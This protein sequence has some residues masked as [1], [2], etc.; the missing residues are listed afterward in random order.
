MPSLLQRLLPR[1]FGDHDRPIAKAPPI[2][3]AHG[4]GRPEDVMPAMTGLQSLGARRPLISS[5]GHIVGFE[6]QVGEQTFQRLVRRGDQ[7]AQAAHVSAVLASARLIGQSGRIGF[8]RFPTGWLL[9]ATTAQVGP[10]TMV[11]LE[12]DENCE[13]TPQLALDTE[14]AVGRLRSAG[15]KV[16]WT[17]SCHINAVPDFLLLHQQAMPMAELLKRMQGLPKAWSAIPVVVTDI[18]NLEDLELALHHGISWGCGAP[19]AL[20]AMPALDKNLPVPPEVRRVGHLLHQL[21]TGAETPDIVAEIKRDVGL[22]YRLLR[23]INSASFAQLNPGTTIEQAA[24]MLGRNELYRWF[25]ML[26]IQFAGQRKTSFALQEITLWHSRLMELLALEKNDPAAGQLF[27]LGLAS[28]L[29]L[30]LK[31]SPTEIAS[32]LNLPETARQALL[33][34][35]GP[36]NV[37]LQTAMELERPSQLGSNPELAHFGG[38][39][40]VLQLSDQAWTW[41]ADNSQR[42]GHGGAA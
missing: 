2:A 22:S 32:A 17:A 6:F 25:S 33:E 9:Q 27:T 24:M 7:R 15:A 10:G 8:A 13:S 16:G 20:S 35:S 19:T 29:A 3:P 31:T 18:A 39:A 23:R 12:L 26:M 4:A 1:L 40:R 37:Y 30:L 11:G 21:V 34:Q 28:M 14:H 41:A 42:D 38:R 36:W 5:E